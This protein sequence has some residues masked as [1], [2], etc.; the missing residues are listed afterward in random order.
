[1]TASGTVLAASLAALLAASCGEPVPPA[2]VPVLSAAPATLHDVGTADGAAALR[3]WLADVRASCGT[4]TRAVID[5]RLDGSATFTLSGGPGEDHFLEHIDTFVDARSRVLIAELSQ[6]FDVALE[7]VVVPE[8][9]RRRGQAA[10]VVGSVWDGALARL[11]LATPSR[12]RLQ[13]T[14]PGAGL[15][16]ATLGSGPRRLRILL[17]GGDLE[18]DPDPRASDRGLPR[19]VRDAVAALAALDTLRAVLGGSRALDE[20][21]IEVVLDASL[22]GDGLAPWW[23]ATVATAAA[24]PVILRLD[25]DPLRTA[26]LED[27]ITVR[28]VVDETVQDGKALALATLESAPGPD[29]RPAAWARATLQPVGG[30]VGDAA[31]AVNQVRDVFARFRPDAGEALA[32]WAEAG[33]VVVLALAQPPAPGVP[34]PPC[35]RVPPDDDAVEI[36]CSFLALLSGDPIFQRASPTGALRPPLTARIPRQARLSASGAAPAARFAAWAFSDPSGRRHLDLMVHGAATADVPPVWRMTRARDSQVIIHASRPLAVDG[37]AVSRDAD[38]WPQRFATLLAR[39]AEQDPEL[40]A[41]LD[42]RTEGVPPR[43]MTSPAAR[44]WWQQS[45][46]R[47]ARGAPTDGPGG[48][49][50]LER[51]RELVGWMLRATAGG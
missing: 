8:P 37:V 2:A 46:D 25:D 15:L 23:A 12:H 27:L 11:D 50:T 3:T 36:L 9:R 34:P 40:A 33:E 13:S 21:S 38:G 31:V 49:P 51:T 28:V 43:P 5:R 42:A 32:V 17:P 48:G 1:M 18:R 16:G 24:P 45:T 26:R 19:L 20:V 29:H 4:E 44:A 10:I 6:A 30:D 14:R 22:G 7:A 47:V 35:L 39:H 41:R